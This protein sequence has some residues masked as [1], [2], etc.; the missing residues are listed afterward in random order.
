MVL[1]GSAL[2]HQSWLARFRVDKWVHIFLFAILVILW[3]RAVWK[4][5]PINKKAMITYIMIGIAG[6]GYGIGMEFVQRYFVF[7]R[8]YDNGDILA[9]GLGCSI[10]VLYSVLR[11][12]KK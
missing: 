2:P 3:A 12:I 4:K 5:S 1:P 9:D 10:G 8:S 7:H 11:Y 6:L